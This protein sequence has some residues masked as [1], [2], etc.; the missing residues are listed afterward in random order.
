[1]RYVIAGN[2]VAGIT[3]ALT[4]RKRDPAASIVVISGESDFFFSRTALMYAYMDR[5]DL[6]GLEPYERSVYDTQ[7]IER[8]RAWIEDVDSD[9][10]LLRL[11]GGGFLPYDR[12]LIATGSVANNL[13]WMGMERVQSGAVNF[14]SLQDLTR[15]EQ[16]TPSTRHAIVVGGG[17]IGIELVE[18]LRHHGVTVT[19]LVREP[20]YW[21]AALHAGES[22]LV[23]EH[24]RAHGVDLRLNEQVAEV[25][26]DSSGRV[27]GVR[28]DQ[29]NT[30]AGQMLGITAGVRPAVD[31]LRNMRRPLDLGRGVVVSPDFR[32]SLPDIWAAGDCAEIRRS[33]EKPFVEQ[34]WYSAKLQGELAAFSMLGD[35][36][37]YR[38]PIF[39]NSSKFFEIE[40]TTVGMVTSAPDSARQFFYRVP[41][42]NVSIRLL[43]LGGAVI[44]FNMLGSRWD[45]T[46]FERWISERRS[47][48]YAMANLER[49][50]FDVE[51]GRLDLRGAKAAYA[52]ERAA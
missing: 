2:G 17:L 11:E 35:P 28:T 20:W 24:I 16:L 45:H 21:P 26:T 44:G 18:C 33:G 29:G 46:M 47:M 1:M 10:H 5:L 34:I 8:K 41:G 23:S 12:L 6:R 15:C 32:A 52:G 49:A 48:D 14:V 42:K 38:P 31:W 40:F 3:A 13:T 30:I 43:A 51:F 27:S 22:E 50:Q 4:L 39:Y 7:R 37:D 9:E 36:V 25:F 19:F